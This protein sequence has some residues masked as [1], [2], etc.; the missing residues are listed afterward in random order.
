MTARGRGREG[1]KEARSP[2]RC[3]SQRHR[4]EIRA[5]SSSSEEKRGIPQREV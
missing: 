3:R 5:L 4:N 2:D 1:E